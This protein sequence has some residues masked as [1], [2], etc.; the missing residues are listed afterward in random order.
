MLENRR[1][2]DAIGKARLFLHGR[3]MHGL[4]LIVATFAGTLLL[5]L[6]GVVVIA[7][8][9]LLLVALVSVL[10]LVPVIALGA[11]VLLP[12]IAV[13]IAMVGTLRSSIWTVGY[14]TEAAA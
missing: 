8:V 6:A 13:L 2:V 5:G 10:G 11:L 1:A 14:L 12:A 9:V 3:L 4:K 7:P